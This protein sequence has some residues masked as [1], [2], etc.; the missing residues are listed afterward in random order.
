MTYHLFSQ[1][2]KVYLS[3]HHPRTTHAKF[4]IIMVHS[5]FSTILQYAQCHHPDHEILCS[6]PTHRVV[7]QQS[8]EKM[9]QAKRGERNP[10]FH[11]L[12]HGHREKLRL[13]NL[14][15]RG[16][17]HHFYNRRHTATTKLRMSLSQRQL[18]PRKWCQDGQGGTHFVFL[19][20]DLPLGWTWG[21]GR[22]FL[23]GHLSM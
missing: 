6:I 20:F 5:C 7:T 13:A 9:S 3:H 11:G 16:E 2:K 18:P 21:R 12:S 22:K 10:N 4:V 19:P 1:G 14:H 17:F 8:R 15:R 23:G